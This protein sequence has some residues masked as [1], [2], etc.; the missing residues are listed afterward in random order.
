MKRIS[1]IL[2]IGAVLALVPGLGSAEP[3]RIISSVKFTGTTVE[4][5]VLLI[6]TLTWGRP[7][8]R[9][10]IVKLTSGE[11]IR[12][13]VPIA[14]APESCVVFP[15]D[16]ATV[17]RLENEMTTEPIYVVKASR[18]GMTA[19]NALERTG[20][21]RGPRLPAAPSSWPA[22]QLDR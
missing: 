7:G 13:V 1:S 3:P 21:Q 12:A 15:G 17:T 5:E 16:I 18:A 20:G 9:D 14:C 6:E 22:A 19:N 11:I 4:G 8:R 10:A 2:V